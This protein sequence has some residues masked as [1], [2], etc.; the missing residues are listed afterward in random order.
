[1]RTCSNNRPLVRR[2]ILLGGLILMTL[3]GAGCSAGG[4]SQGMNAT[5]IEYTFW[6]PF[7][8]EP[9]IQH[10]ISFQRSSDITPP[11]KTSALETLVFGAEAR[12]DLPIVK[13]Y[14]VAM[15]KG[16]I[17]VCD[18]R[19]SSVV[20]LDLMARETRLMG[21]RGINALQQPTDIAIADDGT[22][23][24]CDKIRRSVIV[25]D[26]DERF[27][28]VFGWPDFEPV[29]AAVFG[30]ELYVCDAQAQQVVVLDRFSGEEIRRIGKPGSPDD[31]Y[32]DRGF[33]YPLGIAVDDDGNV[34]VS[35]V[36]ASRVQKFA[37]DG[38]TAVVY[39]V[40]GDTVGQF[41]RPKHVDVDSD[42]QVYV[43]DAAFQNVQ[44]FASDGQLLT[45]FGGA[46][47]Y[48]GAMYL[49]AGICVI[50]LD[51]ATREVLSPYI[52]PA[53]NVEHLILVTNQFG[54]QKVAV[55]GFGSLKEGKTLD[56]IVPTRLDTPTGID[57]AAVED[58]TPP[59][60]PDPTPDD[61]G[62][63]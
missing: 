1:M 12:D 59:E 5:P 54:P 15:W 52:H 46:G 60:D 19:A 41:R 45:F 17:Y 22:M 57:P 33:G 44:V 34:Y 3:L 56:D 30:K 7:P 9:R 48:P 55:Y 21:V 39:G 35:D 36:M 28:A 16:K 49:P 24:V 29:S 50:D 8:N 13:P 42:G 18:I 14:G 6:P 40:L 61:K 38:T 62:Q 58:E 4:T 47:G 10:L 53:F 43:V 20:V 27:A 37:P 51:D 32:E 25:F 31:P 63:P 26:A 11:K 23:Y 2:S